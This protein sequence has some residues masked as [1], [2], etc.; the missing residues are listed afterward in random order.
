MDANVPRELRPYLNRALSCSRHY[1][2]SKDRRALDDAI[3]AWESILSLGAA[4]PTAFD[5]SHPL[6]W[7]GFCYFGV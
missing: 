5:F 7:A 4:K 6:H 3:A 1:A 2:D